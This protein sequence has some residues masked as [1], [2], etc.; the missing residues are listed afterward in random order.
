MWLSAVKQ[1]G[2]SQLLQAG[3][4]DLGKLQV[5]V[6]GAQN[7]ENSGTLDCSLLALLALGLPYFGWGWGTL[8]L[9]A[10]RSGSQVADVKRSF[11]PLPPWILIPCREKLCSSGQLLSP[12]NTGTDCSYPDPSLVLSGSAPAYRN[13]ASVLSSKGPTLFLP[14]PSAPRGRKPWVGSPAAQ[15]PRQSAQPNSQPGS[16]PQIP[17]A[18]GPNC[19]SPA[20]A[21]L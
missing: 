14:L 16:Q 21:A 2:A 8:V 5:S 20:L 7:L 18:P 10:V 13:L 11:T 3:A 15:D 19:L 1:G 9:Q 12:G 6:L 17:K 4:S